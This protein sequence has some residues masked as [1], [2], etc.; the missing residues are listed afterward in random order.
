MFFSCLC[1][2]AFPLMFVILNAGSFPFVSLCSSEV[3]KL[4]DSSMAEF[5]IPGAILQDWVA[6]RVC[7]ECRMAGLHGALQ[8]WTNI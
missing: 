8:R 1:D 2:V 3:C 6:V 5:R 4:L 7:A